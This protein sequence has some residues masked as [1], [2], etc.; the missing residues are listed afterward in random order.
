MNSRTLSLVLGL[1]VITVSCGNDSDF[2]AKSY[3]EASPVN[4]EGEQ[5]TLSMKDFE[6]GMKEELWESPAPV[7][8]LRNVARLDPPAR[9]LK[10]SDDVTMEQNSRP[11][12]QISGTFPLQVI[13]VTDVGAGTDNGTKLVSAKVGVK[14]QHSCFQNPLPLMG[15]RRGNFEH[16]TP[17][18]FLLR[19]TKDGW[20]VEK[21][22]H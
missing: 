5:V 17:A 7:S 13:E 9:A 15:V 6:C 3:L 18:K 4:L 20:K 8:Q 19:Q 12:V 22:V 2:D 21:V 11:Y 16:D 10:F 14:I 1:A